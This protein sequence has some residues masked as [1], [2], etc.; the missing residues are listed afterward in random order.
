MGW[1]EGADVLRENL[2]FAVIY[3]FVFSAA[4]PT[5]VIGP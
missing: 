5:S 3:L 1:G 2:L 4:E